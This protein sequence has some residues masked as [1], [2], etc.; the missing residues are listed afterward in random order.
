MST[1]IIIVLAVAVILVALVAAAVLTRRSAQPESNESQPAP[2]IDPEERRRQRQA[3]VDRGDDL[4]DRRVELDSR[5]GTLGGN[6]LLDDALQEL[7]AR[8]ERGE[9]S[10]AE[11]EVEKTRLLGG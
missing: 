9:I 11:F 4:L 5:R 8:H 6:V 7:A 1:L 3:A 2:E 10:D